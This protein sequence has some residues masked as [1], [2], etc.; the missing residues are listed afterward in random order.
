MGNQNISQKQNEKL[1]RIK[2]EGDFD[3]IKS[4]YILKQIFDNLK[5]N[6]SLEIIKYNKKIQNR[7]NIKINDYI[8]CSETYTKIEIEII[9]KKNIYGKFINI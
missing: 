6:E 9:P 7:L 8:Y 1:E 5:I 3:N 2:K 4:K